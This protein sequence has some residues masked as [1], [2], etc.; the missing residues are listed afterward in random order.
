MAIISTTEVKTYLGIAST[1]TTYDSLIAAYIPT[2]LQEFF[3]LTNNYFENNSVKIISGNITASSSARTLVLSDTNFSTYSF[4]SGDEIRIKDSKRNDGYYT[5]TTVSS[6]TI[7]VSSSSDY[8]ATYTLKDESE[9]EATWTVTKIDIPIAIK[10]LLSAMVKNHI[11][12]PTGR[13]QSESLG[14]YSVTYG[15]II[16]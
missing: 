16:P 2:V 14:D 12:A 5:A 4:V 7:T 9:L 1:D 11:D 10:P 3:D 15:G 8:V 6:A 13:P